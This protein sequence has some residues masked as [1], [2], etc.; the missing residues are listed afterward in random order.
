LSIRRGE[1]MAR[2][3]V[4][5]SGE[6][7]HRAR[8]AA[9]RQ[10]RP[11]RAGTSELLRIA[12][13][14][15]PWI[16]VPP[17]GYGGIET[18]VAL[19]SAELVRRGHAVTL[20]AA[21][22]SRSIAE[23]CPLLERAYPDQIGSACFEADHVALAFAAID[24]ERRRGRP[25]D[26]VH[27][28][29]GFT[30]FAMA[31]RIETPLV[32]TVHGPFDTA[33]TAFYERHA[34]KAS[35]VS[36]SGTQL[37]DAP[38]GLRVVGIVPNPID[39]GAW[40]PASVKEP[41]LLWTGRMTEIKGPHRA[42]RVARMAGMPL[43]LAGPVQPGGEEF[44]EREI[45]PHIDGRR[46]RY[47]G[48][49]GGERKRELFARAQALLMPIS[50]PE[51]FGMVM[52]EAMVCGTPVI[53]FPEGAAREIVIDHTTG[54]LVDD[55]QQMAEACRHA[56]EIDPH[57]CRA[58]VVERFDVGVVALAYERAYRRAITDAATA[59]GPL[60]ADAPR[61]VRPSTEQATPTTATIP[62]VGSA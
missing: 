3:F 15:P 8:T 57:R 37:A 19:L 30:A 32:H 7:A 27:D 45:A 14:A 29:C 23:V 44:F 1:Q 10:R 58:S 60:R 55:E 22:G 54:F 56:A 2:A 47:L 46:V 25:Y 24:A 5:T 34:G 38:A 28:H 59:R 52:V 36:I 4:I 18:V 11:G 53:A 6:D 35:V 51:P 9:A 48:E 17:P 16:P 12:M 49:V 43:V 26:I 50:W 61:R 33:L 39:A 13:L 21:P 40:P 41:F 31:D 62:T 20:F 42:I